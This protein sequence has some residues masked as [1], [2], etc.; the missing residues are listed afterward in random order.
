MDVKN[1]VLYVDKCRLKFHYIIYKEIL[2]HIRCVG[3]QHAILHMKFGSK[4]SKAYERLTIGIKVDHNISPHQSPYIVLSVLKGPFLRLGLIPRL[5]D[6][7][8]PC[9][10]DTL[11]L[12]TVRFG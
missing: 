3:I 10:H 12:G 5:H 9:Q 2:I 7:I 1:L 11:R 4:C 8:F 6:T